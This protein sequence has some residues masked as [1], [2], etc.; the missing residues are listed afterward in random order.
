M[1]RHAREPQ[2]APV[3]EIYSLHDYRVPSVRDGPGLEIGDQSKRAF[4]GTATAVG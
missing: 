4:L 3:D 2:H 1:L